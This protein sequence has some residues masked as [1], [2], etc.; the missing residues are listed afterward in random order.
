MS[1][2]SGRVN[3]VKRTVQFNCETQGQG[4]PHGGVTCFLSVWGFLLPD[5]EKC[6]GNDQERSGGS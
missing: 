2:I 1:G 5:G 6:V 4:G 3:R